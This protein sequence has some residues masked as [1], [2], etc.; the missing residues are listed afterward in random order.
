MVR[1]GSLWLPST[2]SSGPA[3]GAMSSSAIQTPHM[4]RS[5]SLWKWMVS[6][7]TACWVPRWK[8]RVWKA[9]GWRP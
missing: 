2:Y 9:K 5:G 7:C 4:N 8:F 1:M 3:P 6:L